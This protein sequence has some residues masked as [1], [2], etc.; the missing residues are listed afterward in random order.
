MQLKDEEENLGKS[1]GDFETK[2]Y[3]SVDQQ[4]SYHLK[5]ILTTD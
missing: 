3:D 4:S 1:F 2:F 5:C